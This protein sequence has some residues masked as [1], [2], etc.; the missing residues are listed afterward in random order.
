MKKNN[1]IAVVIVALLI[2]G[3]IFV[4]AAFQEEKEEFSVKEPQTC[5]N[6]QQTC[7]QDTCKQE[8]GGNCGI[9]NCGCS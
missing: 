6:P 2:V 5:G 8:C 4:S 1:L 3:T 7:G 9:P